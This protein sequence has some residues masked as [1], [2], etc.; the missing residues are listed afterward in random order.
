MKIKSPEQLR[1]TVKYLGM[2]FVDYCRLRHLAKNLKATSI[3]VIGK[4]DNT[5]G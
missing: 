4:Q 3:T 2:S 5:A 1:E